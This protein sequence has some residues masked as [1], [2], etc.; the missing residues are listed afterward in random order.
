MVFQY[1][2]SETEIA[3]NAYNS[4]HGGDLVTDQSFTDGSNRLGKSIVQNILNKQG[5]QTA[6][7]LVDKDVKTLVGYFGAEMSAWAGNSPF[8]I[9]DSFLG[10]STDNYAHSTF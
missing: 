9:G 2:R 8:G 4:V 10:V 1:V 3:V 7:D 6:S 5:L